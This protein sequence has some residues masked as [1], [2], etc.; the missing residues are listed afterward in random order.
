MK[1]KAVAKKKITKKT[2]AGIPKRKPPVGTGEGG[3]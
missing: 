1:K 2:V 3:G